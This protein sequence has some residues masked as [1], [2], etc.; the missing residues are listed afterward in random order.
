MSGKKII[1]GISGAS[2]SVLG[3]TLLKHLKEAGHETHL[4]MTDNA[5]KIIEHETNYIVEDVENSA[6]HVYDNT[7]FFAPIASGSFKADAMVIIPCSMK[8]LAGIANGFSD[9]LLLRVAD[10]F[11]KERRKLVIVPRETPLSIIHTENMHKVS[12]AG[13]VILPAMMTFYSKPK[14][15]D[16]MVCHIVG[17]VLDVLD[18]ENKVYKRWGE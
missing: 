6:S 9:S 7:D 18:I 14:T 10:V 5:K 12:A 2:G 13:A 1:V 3:I 17:K 4:I 16:E 8:T 11:L 15:V